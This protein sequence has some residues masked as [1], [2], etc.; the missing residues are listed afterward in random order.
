MGYNLKYGQLDKEKEN[1][2]KNKWGRIRILKE[3]GK[4]T[5]EGRRNENEMT[6]SLFCD[7]TQR[8]FLISFRRFGTAYRSHLRE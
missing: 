4:V 6:Y 3:K 5:K 2:K 1:R 7:L 8:C